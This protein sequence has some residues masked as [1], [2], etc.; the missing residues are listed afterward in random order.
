MNNAV[1]M[2]AR[3]PSDVWMDQFRDQHAVL[4]RR[5]KEA[6][7]TTQTPGWQSNYKV[8]R[9]L[10]ER[11]EA[12]GIATIDRELASMRLQGTSEEGEKSIKDAVKAMGEER[13]RFRAWE[14][15]AV[16]NYRKSATELRNYIESILRKARD[17]ER[18]QPLIH[19]GFEDSIK[20]FIVHWANA[21]WNEDL[22]QVVIV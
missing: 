14:S 18:D 2:P 22:G 10:H 19:R 11:S 4:L 3:D 21:E 15:R 5:A 16:E 9:V 12:D 17:N 1:E 8:Q 7:D 13:I 6:A 20:G